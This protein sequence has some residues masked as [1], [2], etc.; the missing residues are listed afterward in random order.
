[1]CLMPGGR[2]SYRWRKR[3]TQHACC[4]FRWVMKCFS[5][6]EWGTSIVPCSRL[7]PTSTVPMKSL[8]RYRRSAR[9]EDIFT[10]PLLRQRTLDALNG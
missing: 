4:A 6:M 3:S 2:Q 8:R 9:G 5:W 10:W 1:M 7:W